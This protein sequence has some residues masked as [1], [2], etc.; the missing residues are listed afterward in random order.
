LTTL[1][2]LSPVFYP[3]QMVPEAARP[4]Y[5][6]NPLAGL[7]TLYHEILYAGRM[8]SLTLLFGM[9]TTSLLVYLIGYAIF[10]RYAD[11]FPEIV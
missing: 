4:F 8:P 3:A 5:F 10:S 6:L 2:Y 7:L 9:M 1:F 11:V